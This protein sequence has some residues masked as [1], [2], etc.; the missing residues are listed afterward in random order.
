M[1]GQRVV[2]VLPDPVY[3]WF[4]EQAEVNYQE[5]PEYLR[6]LLIQ[7]CRNSQANLATGYN[8]ETAQY[9]PLH[10]EVGPRSAPMSVQAPAQAPVPEPVSAPVPAPRAKS[11][12][13]DVEPADGSRATTRS[14]YRGVY[15]YGKR[16]AAVITVNRKQQRIGV[17]DTALEAA[18]AYDNAV[19]ATGGVDVARA[20]NFAAPAVPDTLRPFIE[21]IARGEAMNRADFAAFEAAARIHDARQAQEAVIQETQLIRVLPEPLV[22]D[23]PPRTLRRRDDMFGLVPEDYEPDHGA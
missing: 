4:V 7:L 20:L 9:V 1:N 11:K 5:L 16:W 13:E 19:R 18:H 2:F 14:G 22:I 23:E 17:F 8:A 3:A 6:A 10:P 21:R 12:T 15:P